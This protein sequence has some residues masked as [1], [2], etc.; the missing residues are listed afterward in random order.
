ML[1]ISF[2]LHCFL[3]SFLSITLDM[4]GF[5]CEKMLYVGVCGSQISSLSLGFVSLLQTQ[6]GTSRMYTADPG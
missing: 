5:K 1:V 6:R 2:V 4:W 3:L